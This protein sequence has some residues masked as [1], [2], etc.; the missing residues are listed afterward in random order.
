M[1]LTVAGV[2]VPLPTRLPRVVLLSFVAAVLFDAFSSNQPQLQAQSIVSFP[3]LEA[4]VRRADSLHAAFDVLAALA[5]YDSI[6]VS[7]ENDVDVLWRAAR[8]CVAMGVLAEGTNLQ[9]SWFI[10]GEEYAQRAA[11]LAVDDLNVLHWLQTAKGCRSVQSDPLTTARLATEVRDLANRILESD[12]LHAGA[13]HA[14]G[15]LNYEVM[16]LSRVNRFIG[17]RILGSRAFRGTSWEH[18]EEYLVRAT[19]LEPENTLYWLDLAKLYVRRDGLDQAQAA[20][21]RLMQFPE[22]EPTYRIYKVQAEQLLAQIL[23]R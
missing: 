4:L 22:L 21:N 2:Q 7:H 23:G 14:L 5:I 17:Q 6:L 10:R 13:T 11:D 12:S 18:A 9:N 8:E 3:E 15:V 19:E 1:R 20:I 16:K